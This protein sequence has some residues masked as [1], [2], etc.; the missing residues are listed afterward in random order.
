LAIGTAGQ[1]AVVNAGATAP[2]YVSM[3]GEG[4]LSSTGVFTGVKNIRVQAGIINTTGSF[5]FTVIAPA[6]GT[7]KS[8]KFV[9]K[10]A[11]A[12]NDTN[13][14]TF[15]CVNKGQAGAGTTAMLAATDAN[16]TKS[17]GGTALSAYTARTLTLTGTPADLAITNGDVLLIT[18]A[19]SGT[20]A[21]ALG[22]ASFMLSMS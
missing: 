8:L 4:V 1:F 7:L 15:T 20:L 2:A 10:D 13:Y 3:S 14:I 19:D 11:L 18:L 6:S 22:E 9:A 16:T 5:G 21:N 12:A 17:T